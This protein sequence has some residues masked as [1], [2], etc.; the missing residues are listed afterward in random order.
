MPSVVLAEATWYGSLRSAVEFG[1]GKDGRFSDAGSR[2]GIKGSA[3]AS[4]G[5]TA[6]YRFEQQIRTSDASVH[7]GR[8]AYVGLS[9]GFGTVSAGQIWNAAFNHV[10]VITD[11]SIYYGDSETGYRHGNAVSYAVSAGAMS[12][13]VDVIANNNMETGGAIDQT[14]FGLTVGLG[15]IGKIA[16]AH[17][18][19]KNTQKVTPIVTT[20]ASFLGTFGTGNAAEER[21][22]VAITVETRKSNVGND[23]FLTSTITDATLN[24]NSSGIVRSGTT[25]KYTYGDACSDTDGDEATNCTN[26][27]VYVEIK[28]N[29]SDGNLTGGGDTTTTTSTTY[30][31]VRTAKHVA[32]TSTGGDTVVDEAGHKTSHVAFETNLG[33][34]TAYVGHSTKKEN[35]ASTKSKTTHYGVH[36]AMGDTGM[37]FRAM[38]KSKKDGKGTST[39]PWLLGFSR[40]L[41]GGATVHFEHGNKDNDE[42][43]TTKVGLQVNF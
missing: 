29:T 17:T 43:G 13:Q 21:E 6:V 26:A 7:K 40:S 31:Y 38:A 16:F 36:G 15:D 10:G 8:L 41:G 32:E 39:N 12:M 37:S 42:S 14:E 3:E 5:L 2:W 30:T 4:E 34:I 24:D 33:G 19:K 22:V 28:D 9:G 27:T 20:P 11:N 1:G 18:N 23:G 25:G 35:G